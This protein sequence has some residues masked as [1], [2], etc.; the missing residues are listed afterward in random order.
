LASAATRA[1]A[2]LGPAEAVENAELA[3]RRAEEEAR[4]KAEAEALDRRRAQLEAEEQAARERADLLRK[5]EF[6]RERK[7]HEDR[8]RARQ[9]GEQAREPDL[10]PPLARKSGAGR[11]VAI[12]AATILG[13]GIVGMAIDNDGAIP[14]PDPSPPY[15]VV[16]PNGGDVPAGGDGGARQPPPQQQ[17]QPLTAQAQPAPARNEAARLAEMISAASQPML[18]Q[19]INAMMALT[20]VA[21]EG[22]RL[23]FR[24]QSAEFVQPEFEP[25]WQQQMAQLSAYECQSNMLVSTF[26]ASGGVRIYQFT[27][28]NGVR[29]EFVHDRC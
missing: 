21:A 3:A 16:A 11:F 15:G 22:S 25:M 14:E 29:F 18:P 12:S 23:I 20:D 26:I 17:Q 24:V 27:S 13:L 9:R 7:L 8:A 5:E 4:L 28:A 19:A 2:R 6:E 1:L 10:P